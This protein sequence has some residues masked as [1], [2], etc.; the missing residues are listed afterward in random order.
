MSILA[1]IQTKGGHKIVDLNRRRAIRLRCWD[2]SGFNYAEVSRCQFDDCPLF[3]FRSGK[4]RQ[5]AK[6]RNKAIHSY[7]LWCCAD[8]PS[9]VLKCPALDCPLWSFRKGRIDKATK[10]VSMP[11][12]GHIEAFSEAI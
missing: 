12:K 8:Q 5:D 10:N 9:E 6:D 3:P 11:E 7:C 1:K 2:C 4:G